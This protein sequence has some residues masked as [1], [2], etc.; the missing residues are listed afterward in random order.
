MCWDEKRCSGSLKDGHVQH[1]STN[2]D[3]RF[4]VS[5]KKKKLD[6][7]RLLFYRGCNVIVPTEGSQGS[8]L[9]LTGYVL[10][11]LVCSEIQ[12]EPTT[13]IFSVHLVCLF[14]LR[15]DLGD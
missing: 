13:D 1:V 15:E 14:H 9:V 7:S 10:N 3:V 8:L 11:Q 2:S 6:V 12:R 4:D 5:R